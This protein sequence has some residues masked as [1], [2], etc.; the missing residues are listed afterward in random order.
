VAASFSG[1]R[2]HAPVPNTGSFGTFLYPI[3]QNPNQTFFN[4][5]T[6]WSWRGKATAYYNLPWKIVTST[7][8]EACNGLYGQ[9]LVNYTA[10]NSGIAST[11]GTVPV[12]SSGAES[13]PA[14]IVWNI[15]AGREFLFKE[16]FRL[17]P[18]VS[19]L[20]LLNRA[21]QWAVSFTTG[22]TFLVPSVIDTSRIARFGAVFNF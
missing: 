18:Y 11:L 13:G 16:K 9:R 3:P 7:T 15:Q 19:I 12:E 20:N 8:F 21:D 22:P 10:A 2:D 17:K 14:R 1:I 5:D 4:E 6:T